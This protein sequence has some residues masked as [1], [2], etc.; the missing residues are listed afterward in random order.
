MAFALRGRKRNILESLL[1][2][3]PAPFYVQ[4]EEIGFIRS[5]VD[6]SLIEEVAETETAAL[7][8]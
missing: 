5:A 3:P 2:K 6:E 8:L 7:A 1:G 4:N